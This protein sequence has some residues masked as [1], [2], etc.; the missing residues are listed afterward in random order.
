MNSIEIKRPILI[1]VVITEDFKNQMINESKEA[2][3]NI[4]KNL[5]SVKGSD[6]PEIKH[7]AE[8]FARLKESFLQKIKDFESV[9][10]GAELPFRNIEGI[11]VVNVGD[12]ILEKLTAT[13]VVIKDWIVQEIRHC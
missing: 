10:L 11:A 8:E 3:A 9:T 2:I 13:E 1:K 7:Q 12:N 5:E 6:N 4:D